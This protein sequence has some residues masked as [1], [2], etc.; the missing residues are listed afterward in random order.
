MGSQ[1]STQTTTIPG[2]S[3]NE[4]QLMQLLTRLAQQSGGQLGNLGGLAQGQIGGPSAQDYDLVQQ[5]IGRSGEMAQRELQRML[6]PLMA[7]LSEG[8]TQRNV[9][10]SS[11]EQLSKILGGREIAEQGANILSGAQMQGGQALMN[12]PFQRAELQLG[13]NQQLFQQLIGAAN[14]VM[15]NQLQSRLAQ[16]TTT[17]E[18]PMNPMSIFQTAAGLGGLPFGGAL[19]GLFG[20]GGGG[21]GGGGGGGGS[22]AGGPMSGLY[23]AYR[24]N[25]Q[26]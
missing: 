24:M 15:A 10:G 19:G 5:T 7:Q 13:A 11:L 16:Q 3:G 12:L 18:T 14:P 21:A 25:Q 4:A 26:R 2:A 6:G 9:P 17:A 8:T 23:N 22:Y 20:G 1:K